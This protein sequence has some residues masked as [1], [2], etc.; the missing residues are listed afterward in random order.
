[1]SPFL[2]SSSI[3][4]PAAFWKAASTLVWVV[5]RLEAKCVTKSVHAAEALPAPAA[6]ASEAGRLWDGEWNPM[7]NPAAEAVIQTAP[8][9][10]ATAPA[11]KPRMRRWRKVAMLLITQLIDPEMPC[12]FRAWT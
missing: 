7:F 10:M 8:T 4:W 2:T 5:P 9:A 11:A 6:V 1:M 3:V 12:D